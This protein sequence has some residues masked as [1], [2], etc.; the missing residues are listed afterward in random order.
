MSPRIACVRLPPSEQTVSAELIGALLCAAPRVTP[1]RNHPRALW[2]DAAGMERRGGDGAVARALLEAARGAGCTGAKVGIAGTCIAAAA[3]TRE[4]GTPARVVPRGADARYLRLRPLA[5]LPMPADLRETLRLLGVRAC[6]ELAGLS[7]ADVELRFGAPGLAAWRLARADDP[8]WPFRPAHPGA[9]VAEAGFEPPVESA[10]PLRFVLPGLVAAVCA[11][12]AERQRIP[13]GLSLTLRVETAAG[14]VDD[15]REVRPARPTADPRVLAD[16]CRRAV[17]ERPLAGPLASVRLEVGAAGAARADQLDAFRAPAPDPGAL[18]AALAPVFARW[19]AGAL[20]RGVHHGAHLPGEHAAWEALGSGGI[21]PFAAAPGPAEE[22]P[23]ETPDLAG[24]VLSLC[25]R[26]L[27]E[28]R[29][30]RVREGEGGRPLGVDFQALNPALL[31]GGGEG[32]PPPVWKT[33]AEGPERISAGWWTGG[34]AR[35]YWRIESP[36]GWLGLLFR[37]G[38]SGEWY[39]EGWYD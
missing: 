1:V 17:E 4:R 31:G 39:V 30:V 32:F 33:I 35:E 12:L 5:L 29:R 20:S 11:R 10:E 37:D 2:A 16:L 27:A 14:A 9:A 3:A 36:Q 7:P 24:G 22:A 25:L 26:R 19:G 23:E 18:H 8:R 28:P 13:A 21:A 15:A 34:T 6:G 38:V